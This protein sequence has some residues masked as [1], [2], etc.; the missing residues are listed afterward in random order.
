MRLAEVELLTDEERAATPLELEA[1]GGAVRPGQTVQVNAT[2]FN[3]GDA[4]QSGQVTASA[5]QGWT[6]TPAS[7]PFGPIGRGESD[8]LTFD[9]TVPAGTELGTYAIELTANG[10]ARVS[11]NVTV[12]GDV[13]EF[14]P[15]TAAEEP[16]L[17]DADGSQF[18]GR[19]RF[20]DNERYFVYRF[21]IRRG[22]DR[23]NAQPPPAGGVPRPGFE[24]R[25]ELEDGARGDAADH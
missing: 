16:W 24:R 7:A 14:T 25:H 20:A 1:T 18:D 5:P 10:S 2:V 12:V 4:S 15:N 6:V 19:G 21:P 11:A 23:R 13:V 3:W 8:E 9:V 17:F 22:R